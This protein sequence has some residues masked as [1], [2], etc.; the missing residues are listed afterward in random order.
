MSD[1]KAKRMGDAR[2]GVA[3]ID[4][5]TTIIRALVRGGL[6]DEGGIIIDEITERLA[7]IEEFAGL[8]FEVLDKLLEEEG[9]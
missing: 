1:D 2:D 8:A 6:W 9:K 5:H 3:T 7:A 4:R